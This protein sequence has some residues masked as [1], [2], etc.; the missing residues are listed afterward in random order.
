MKDFV[1]QIISSII[2]VPLAY[3]A[4]YK[5]RQYV[6]KG[7]DFLLVCRC[8]ILHNNCICYSPWITNDL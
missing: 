6:P 2:V 4:G 1:S 5:L 7:E 3:L 8:I